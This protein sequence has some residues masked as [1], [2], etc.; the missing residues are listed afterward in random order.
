MRAIWRETW[1]DPD[2]RRTAIVLFGSLLFGVLATIA[3][4][5]SFD[6]SIM[7]GGTVPLLSDSGGL[8]GDSQPNSSTTVSPLVLITVEAPISSFEAG[9]ML[10]VAGEFGAL[11]GESL[12]I[13]KPESYR[14]LKLEVGVAQSLSKKLNFGLYARAGFATRLA[15]DTAPRDRAPRWIGAGLRFKGNASELTVTL[16]ADQRLSSTA[17]LPTTAPSANAGVAT[18]AYQPTVEI[19]G[20]VPL[21]QAESGTLKGGKLSIYVNAVLGMDW[22]ARGTSQTS[23]RHDVVTAGVL[24]GF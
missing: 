24:V 6:Y 12:A 19:R 10:V 11:P 21:Y 4:A 23:A 15:G 22:S 13:D 1:D 17:D 14:S 7:A 3:T 9:P 18:L 20:K 8:V 5:Q 2:H 16:N